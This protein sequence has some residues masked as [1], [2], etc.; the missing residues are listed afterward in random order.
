MNNFSWPRIKTVDSY[1]KHVLRCREYK[2]SHMSKVHV[3]RYQEKKPEWSMLER[4]RTSRRSASSRSFCENWTYA[5]ALN[6]WYC[7]LQAEEGEEEE[8]RREKKYK[9]SIWFLKLNLMQLLYISMYLSTHFDTKYAVLLTE[10]I[11]LALNLHLNYQPF[12]L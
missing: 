9:A 6:S 12:T 2:Y 4:H 1:A 11:C 7:S 5:S 8:G 10:D 3:Q